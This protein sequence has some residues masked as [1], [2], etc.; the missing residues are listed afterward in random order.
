MNGDRRIG[1]IRRGNG[2]RLLVSFLKSAKRIIVL[3]GR[4]KIRDALQ[5][6]RGFHLGF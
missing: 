2:S 6:S 1:L 5:H 4:N 3:C